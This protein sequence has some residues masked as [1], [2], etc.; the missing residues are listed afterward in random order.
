MF[1]QRR[2]RLCRPC[3][4]FNSDQWRAEKLGSV[5]FRS[6]SFPSTSLFSRV[7]EHP[8]FLSLWTHGFREVSNHTLVSFVVLDQ[9]LRQPVEQLFPPACVVY[10]SFAALVSPRW[11]RWCGSK[12]KEFNENEGHGSFVI[13]RQK[14]AM[15]PLDSGLLSLAHRRPAS[16]C[17]Q[18][19]PVRWSWRF[20]FET[21][22]TKASEDRERLNSFMTGKLWNVRKTVLLWSTG[23]N[24]IFFW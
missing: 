18:L 10:A 22:R 1:P 4:N 20:A 17:Q 9:N 7:A 24:V 8:G 23:M 21:S 5:L 13:I 15:K 16:S 11:L 12:K 14:E 3:L 2:E 19:T 6:S